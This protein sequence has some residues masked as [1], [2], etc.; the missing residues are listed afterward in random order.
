MKQ[1][2]SATLSYQRNGSQ[3]AAALVHSTAHVALVLFQTLHTH[4]W[5]A[6]LLILIVSYAS[7]EL[8]AKLCYTAYATGGRSHEAHTLQASPALHSHSNLYSAASVV[9]VHTASST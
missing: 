1:S 8:L 6:V 9:K 3:S 5:Y 7:R 2:R 4:E